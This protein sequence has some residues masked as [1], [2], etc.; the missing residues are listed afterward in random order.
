MSVPGALAALGDLELTDVG[1]R[2]R[3]V[4]QLEAHK[5]IIRAGNLTRPTVSLARRCQS[6][7]RSAGWQ[8]RL[9]AFIAR[10]EGENSQPD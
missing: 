7:P 6:G 10:H 4:D 2:S 8:D 5:D 1:V 3:I 9:K